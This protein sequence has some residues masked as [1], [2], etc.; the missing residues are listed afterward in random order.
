MTYISAALRRQVEQRANYYC[1]FDPQTKEFSFL[2][3]P[4]KQKWEEHFKLENLKIQGLTAE[5]RTTAKLLQLNTD[6]RIAERQRFWE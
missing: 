6:E 4:R 5:G 3:H 2:F 1:E